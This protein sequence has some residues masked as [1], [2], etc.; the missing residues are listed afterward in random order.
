MVYYTLF[1]STYFF[2][3][4]LGV[5]DDIGRVQGIPAVKKVK[6]HCCNCMTE[7]TAGTSD[8]ERKRHISAPDESHSDSESSTLLLSHRQLG[9]TSQLLPRPRSSASLTDMI[10][11]SEAKTASIEQLASDDVSVCNAALCVCV[12][13]QFV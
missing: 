11:S 9:S 10:D 6:N 12:F 13:E 5:P 2:N 1:W 8:V 3:F 7:P 4:D